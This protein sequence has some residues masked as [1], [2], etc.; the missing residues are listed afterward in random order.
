MH[1]QDDNPDI[2]E[3]GLDDPSGIN[4]VEDRHAHVHQHK[5][6]LLILNSLNGSKSILRLSNDLQVGLFFKHIAD[7]CQPSTQC[8][9]PAEARYSATGKQ[10]QRSCPC[11]SRT[12]SW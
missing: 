3:L 5:I 11:S 9:L 8:A 2:R 7:C 6:R 10:R 12:R 1:S 4:A